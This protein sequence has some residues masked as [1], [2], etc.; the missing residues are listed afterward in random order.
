MQTLTEEDVKRIHDKYPHLIPSGEVGDYR[1]TP[2]TRA[3]AVAEALSDGINEIGFD[4]KSFAEVLAGDHRTLQQGTM[5]AFSAFVIVMADNYG[6]G[7][8]DGRNQASGELASKLAPVI[9]DSY[10]PF[11]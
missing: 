7:Y 2:T 5:R 3:I 9:K 11:V 8:F 10:L 6:K 4:V 1:S